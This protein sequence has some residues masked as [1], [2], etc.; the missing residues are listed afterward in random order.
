MHIL[1]ELGD[2]LEEPAAALRPPSQRRECLVIPQD[3]RSVSRCEFVCRERARGSEFLRTQRCFERAR[4]SNLC[5]CSRLRVRSPRL[6]FVERLFS[7]PD[8]DAV[9]N[10]ARDMDVGFAELVEKTFGIARRPGWR[11]RPV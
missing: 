8:A 3:L 11:S 7:G 5:L 2:R 6:E 9:R 4:P 1:V 10:D